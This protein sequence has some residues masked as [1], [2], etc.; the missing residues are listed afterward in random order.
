[1]TR[2][3]IPLVELSTDLDHLGQTATV[4]LNQLIETLDGRLVPDGSLPSLHAARRAAQSLVTHL[5][6]ARRLVEVA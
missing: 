6:C 4:I 5:D 1:M 3:P 2:T